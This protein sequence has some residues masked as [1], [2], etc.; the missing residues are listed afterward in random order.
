M[1]RSTFVANHLNATADDLAG[2]QGVGRY[3]LLP[4]SDGRAKDIAASFHHLKVNA[5]P[6]GHHLYLGTLPVGDREIE[7]AAIASGMGCPSMEII[8]H[9]LFHLGAK[10]FLR[11]GTAGPLQTSYVHAC[12]LINVQ[13]AVRDEK[14]SSDYAPIALPAVASLEMVTTINEAAK[15][16]NVQKHLHTGIVHCKS[17]LFAREFGAGPRSEENNAYLAL[18]SRCGVL[19]SE[20]ETAEL[21]IQSQYYHHQLMEQGQGP[22][23]KVLSGAIVLVVDVSPSQSATERENAA[24]KQM[25]ALALETV[26]LLA[27]KDVSERR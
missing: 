15:Q 5:H 19:A 11:V 7:V 20:M 24:I 3:I 26:K 21:F 16:L 12:D 25:N 13:A 1:K 10:R 14:T 23:Y 18:L 6:R 17:S 4:G 9:E 22:T 2:N 27:D 8:L